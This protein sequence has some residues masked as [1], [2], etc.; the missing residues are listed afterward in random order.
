MKRIQK[1]PV[2]GISLK[3]Q[4]EERERRMEFVPERSEVNTE[5]IQVDPDTRDMLK[6]RGEAR[7]EARGGA[8]GGANGGKSIGFPMARA[9][10]KIS[11]SRRR[12]SKD[13]ATV[14]RR[15]SQALTRARTFPAPSLAVKECALQLTV[16]DLVG[17]AY[18]DCAERDLCGRRDREPCCRVTPSFARQGCQLPEPPGEETLPPSRLTS[19]PGHL[20]PPP[21][22]ELAVEASI[23]SRASSARQSE[24]TEAS[25]RSR[26]SSARQSEM[27][28]APRRASIDHLAAKVQEAARAL[29]QV[30]AQERAV[31]HGKAEASPATSV[32]KEV[33]AWAVCRSVYTR[34]AARP[35][36]DKEQS[37][38]ATQVEEVRCW[39]HAVVQASRDQLDAAVQATPG[40]SRAAAVQVQAPTASTAIQAVQLPIVRSNAAVQVETPEVGARVRTRNDFTG[41]GAGHCF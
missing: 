20:P 28:E 27:T 30:E 25:I 16:P 12:D 19:L 23:R 2:R 11:E 18:H 29:V 35:K 7:G 26:A 17:K 24:M 40:S 8:N 13:D 14:V 37:D 36:V 4:E 6:A 31:A 15:S 3:L 33:L 9:S 39:A 21:E 22:A 41:R 32:R 10:R 38:A 34:V 1:G 5:Y